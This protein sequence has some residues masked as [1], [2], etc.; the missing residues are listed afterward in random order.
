MRI[1]F[2]KTLLLLII[3]LL[4]LIGAARGYGYEHI[5]VLFL[6]VSII[7][8]GFIWLG[9]DIKWTL[10]SKIAGLFIFTL[11]ISTALST[12]PLDSLFGNNPYF[13]GLIFYTFLYLFYLIVKTFKIN[14]KTYSL[15]LVISALIVSLLAISQWIQLNFLGQFIPTYAGRVVSTFGQPNFY[16]GYLLLILPFCYFLFTQ[17]EKNLKVIGW[18]SGLIIYIGIMV[19]YSRTAVFLSL[20]LLTLV[21]VDQ[22]RVKIFHVFILTCFI[23]AIILSINFSSGFIYDHFLKPLSTKNP[24]L[25]K[26][27]VEDRVYIWPQA[28][29][30][31]LQKPLPGFGLDNIDSAFSQY[32]EKNKHPIFEE[33]LNISPVLISLKDVKLD[34][35]HNYLLD[36]LL[37]SG[38]L[39]VLGWLGLIGLLFKKLRQSHDGHSKNVLLISLMTYLIWIQFQNQ[40]IVQLVY[41]WL[42]VGMIDQEGR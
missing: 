7:L 12:N 35:T 11:F 10:I 38:I 22:L 19:S 36:L 6:I 8:I 5:K 4:P 15:T 16:A 31:A 26:E 42:L 34:R 3:F 27:S 30:I 14:L 33:N 24:D 2:A 39:G 41:F 20:F 28:V 25:T 29:K 37:F 23:A 13:Q 32:F 21:L 1:S 18:V 40:S 9:K 17:K